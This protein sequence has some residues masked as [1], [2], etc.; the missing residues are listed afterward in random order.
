VGNV[1]PISGSVRDL[2][3]L[4]GWVTSFERRLRIR[5][6]SP[7]TVALYGGVAREFAGWL[8]AERLP[9]D[10]AGITPAHVEGYVGQLQARC[11]PA[12]VSVRFRALQQF[13]K[14]LVK[15]EEI[16]ASPMAKIETPMV[17]EVPV[18]VVSDD[19]I[20]TLLRS[21]E[22]KDFENRRDMA[23]LRLFL[24]TGM[25]LSEL[26]G[27][28]VGDVDFVSDEATVLGKGRRPRAIPFDDHTAVALERYLRER[29]KH[30]WAKRS[31]ALWLAP[32]GL[33]SASGIRQMLRRRA[34]QLGLERLHP[35]MLRHTAAHHYAA[36][37]GQETAMMRNFGWRS[38]AMPKRYGA[39]A[40][41]ERAREKR[42]LG[43][44]N[45]F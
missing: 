13:F 36:L 18:P 28:A 12:T 8:A 9:L 2:G 32:K 22:G 23:I 40:A 34:R 7:R 29:A 5:N 14:F 27:L 39:S 45:R 31:D 15:E 11:R 30:P 17:P 43:L 6:L 35:H 24:D 16:A 4:E 44:G 33:L 38:S 20:A 19:D 1:V 26:A 10:V 21:C 3:D 42:R 37:G 41:D 25:R